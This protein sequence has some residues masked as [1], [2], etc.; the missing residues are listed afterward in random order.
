MCPAIV[1]NEQY[2]F[3]DT[4]GFGTD[5]ED[6]DNHREIW[7]CLAS[8]GPLVTFAGVLFVWGGPE[9]RMTF[10]NK[11]TI[12]WVQSF[13]GPKLFKNITVVTTMWDNL[14]QDG[15]EQNWGLVEELMKDNDMAQILNPPAPYHGGQFYHHGFPE[16]KGGPAAFSNVI[17]MKRQPEQRASEI[18]GLISRRYS[19]IIDCKPQ[20][21]LEVLSGV[22][23]M[24]T[25]AAK[26]LA[27]KTAKSQVSIR[28]DRVVLE[29]LQE[30]L[31]ATV[32]GQLSTKP[33]PPKKPSSEH[34]PQPELK[35]K[36]ESRPEP[37]S[38]P[39]KSWSQSFLEWFQVAKEAAVFFRDMRAAQTENGRKPMW[40]MW[41]RFKDWWSG[42]EPPKA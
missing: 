24:A 36:P 27:F 22:D 41:G 16:G 35:Q 9:T 34:K 3:V 13:C 29:L 15:L 31:R 14:S 17:S 32:P 37:K 28:E 30:P 10:E 4:P 42:E 19:K 8:L 5:I 38:A 7:S 23:L 12:R 39:E 25:E 26:V 21:M 18:K 11:Q 20:I 33:V 1:G 40:V 2:L 6:A